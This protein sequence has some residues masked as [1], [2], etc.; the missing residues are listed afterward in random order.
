MATFDCASP[1]VGCE[2]ETVWE[3]LKPREFPYGQRSMFTVVVNAIALRIQSP[4]PDIR[5]QTPI[6]VEVATR[7]KPAPI[8][9]P[10][11]LTGDVALQKG[12]RQVSVIATLGNSLQPESRVLVQPRHLD[13]GY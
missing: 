7:K 10:P 9:L 4:S 12:V 8:V 11:A 13:V 3:G 1:R 2:V 6:C 5:M